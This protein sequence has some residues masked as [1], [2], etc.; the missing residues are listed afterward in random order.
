MVLI[1]PTRRH[2][3]PLRLLKEPQ[4]FRNTSPAMYLIRPV[5][6]HHARSKEHTMLR[7][8]MMVA[9]AAVALSTGLRVPDGFARGGSHAAARAGL[10]LGRASAGAAMATQQ[11]V[12]SLPTIPGPHIRVPQTG[13]P[14]SQSTLSR[15]PA[16]TGDHAAADGG[17]WQPTQSHLPPMFGTPR[18]RLALRRKLWTGS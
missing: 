15:N 10:G 2:A 11:P 6:T 16:I 5:M 3:A 8:I 14:V 12:R 7:K 18:A 9:T 4:R 1:T 17:H 13:N